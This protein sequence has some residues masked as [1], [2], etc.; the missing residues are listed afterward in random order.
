GEVWEWRA[1]VDAGAESGQDP[2]ASRV[3]AVD[4]LAQH[5]LGCPCAAPFL[6]DELYREVAT[7]APYAQLTRADFDAVVDFVATGGYALKAYE[8]FALIRQGNDRR[9]PIAQPIP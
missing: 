8:R 9:W 7:A 4:V 6:A 2:P 1:A 3:G 5:G